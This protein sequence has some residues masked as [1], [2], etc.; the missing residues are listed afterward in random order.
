MERLL[1]QLEENIHQL[2]E[3]KLNKLVLKVSYISSDAGE[4]SKWN[5]FQQNTHQTTHRNKKKSGFHNEI[6]FT[7]T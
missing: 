4:K 5:Q 1:K 3:R 2:K 6:R 7:S